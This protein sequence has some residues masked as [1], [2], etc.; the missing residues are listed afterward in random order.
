MESIPENKTRILVV[1][2]DVGLLL[3]VKSI[4]SS[5]GMQEPALLADSRRV[6]DLVREHHFHLILL[7]LIM[8]HI[9][10]MEILQ[11]LKKE[12]PEIECVIITAIDEVDTAVQAMKYGAYDY[13]VKP[14]ENE[15]LLI[16]IDRALERYDL[17][18]KIS[19]ME[20]RQSLKD[21]RDPAA[22]E[23]MVTVSDKMALVFHQ[24]EAFAPNDYNLL[25]TGETGTGKEMLARIVHS[26][27]PRG[28]GAFMAVNMGAFN[29]TLF[30]NEFFGHTKGSYT[31]AIDARRGFFEEAQHGTLFLDEISELELDMQPKLLRVIEERE[32]YRL[33][34]SVVH[35]TDVRIISATNRELRDEIK[36]GQFRSDLYYR[37]NVCHIH[38]PP[39]RERKADIL[40]LA[41]HFLKMYAQKNKKNIQELTPDLMDALLGY[42]F[43]GNVRELE[44][45]IASA[46]TTAKGKT[47]TY[48]SMP[49]FLPHPK[50][51]LV[52]TGDI[53]PLPELEKRHI[54]DVLKIVEGNRTKAASLLG[55][56]LRT[57]QRKLKDLGH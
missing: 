15:K 16:T 20:Q 53:L 10:G 14:I 34:S 41:R 1:D 32:V 22:F 5:T 12:F 40:P 9:G 13:L 21:L 54:L 46:V 18:H 25:L 26:L 19:L 8:P 27:S 7:D 50:K 38:I 36:A 29:K 57:L 30:E 17:R 28:Q 48:A 33:G 37:L 31:G 56:G 11:K 3:S 55:I 4:L 42:P 49:D 43:P 2:D 45:M 47:L 52:R 23:S 24:A 6:M 44:N 39:L 35:G 51:G